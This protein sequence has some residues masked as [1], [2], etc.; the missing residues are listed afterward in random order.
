MAD[1]DLIVIGSGPG[2]YV[3]AIRASQLE[4]AIEIATR[5]KNA[6]TCA[7]NVYSEPRATVSLSGATRAGRL[8]QAFVVATI[9]GG[10]NV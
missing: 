5:A 1:F 8:C 7:N 2:G 10:C 4:L 3:S 6:N 9:R